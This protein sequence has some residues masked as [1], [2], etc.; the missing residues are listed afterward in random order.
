MIV[1]C[2]LN[3]SPFHLGFSIKCELRIILQPFGPESSNPLKKTFINFLDHRLHLLKKKLL[4]KFS[5]KFNWFLDI[6][7]LP[8]F[9]WLSMCMRNI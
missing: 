3:I 1:T 6:Q 9:H 7:V 5:S 8:A 2:K 4:P